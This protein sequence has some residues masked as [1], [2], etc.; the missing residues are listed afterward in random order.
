[1]QRN[2]FSLPEAMNWAGEIPREE[3]KQV[4]RYLPHRIQTYPERGLDWETAGFEFR[5]TRVGIDALSLT[6]LRRLWSLS[7]SPFL[8]L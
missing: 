8:I 1:M 4:G 6:S 7:E 5:P 3:G 2:I